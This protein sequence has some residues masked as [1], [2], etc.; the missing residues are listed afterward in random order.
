MRETGK[1]SI[2][3]QEELISIF[4]AT[5]ST[6]ETRISIKT[7]GKVKGIVVVKVFIDRFGKSSLILSKYVQSFHMA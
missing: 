5:S 6:K 2:P 1:M 3:V 7:C 4:M